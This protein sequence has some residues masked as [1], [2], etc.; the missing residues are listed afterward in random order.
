MD[1][2]EELYTIEGDSIVAILL[3]QFF[4]FFKLLNSDT[5][6]ISIAAGVCLGFILAMSPLFSLQAVL[7]IFVIFFFRV[8]AGAAMASAFFFAFPAYLLDPIFH[9]AGDFVLS[10]GSL[11]PFFAAL[12]NMP[13]I[14][15]TRF[16]NTIVMG[17]GVVAIA[18]FP[19]LFLLTLF[20]VNR[21]R[22]AVVA[23]FKD[24]K[25][26]KSLKVTGFYKWYLKYDQLFG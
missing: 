16:N 7:V 23:R 4:K 9:R 6:A 1:T 14:P 22:Q 18:L 8:Q 26:F 15:F 2:E 13:I 5:G 25:I 17:S 19:V 24:S 11:E 10:Q 12:Y 3:K 21:Y 20:L